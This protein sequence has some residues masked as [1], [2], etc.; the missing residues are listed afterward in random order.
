M[1]Q[2]S[3][4]MFLVA[5]F[6]LVYFGA[7]WWP[8]LRRHRNDPIW[9]LAF[10]IMLA[11]LASLGRTLYEAA[12]VGERYRFPVN[13]WVASPVTLFLMIVSIQLWRRG[14]R[15]NRGEAK[16]QR[17]DGSEKEGLATNLPDSDGG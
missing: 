10:F 16:R 14:L 17:A 13:L 1:G 7:G 2:F 4:L 12:L 5:I 15:A 8:R 11:C 6:G 3:F 9:W